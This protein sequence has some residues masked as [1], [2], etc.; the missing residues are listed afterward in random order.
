MKRTSIKSI[1]SLKSLSKLLVKDK[2]GREFLQSPLK[3]PVSR[4]QSSIP[5]LS[6]KSISSLDSSKR[7]R[8]SL[9]L[10]KIH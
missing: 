6:I 4:R 7:V 9:A 8:K 1:K 2:K 3:R 10:N 5:K